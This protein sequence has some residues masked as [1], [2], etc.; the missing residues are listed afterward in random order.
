MWREPR[1]HLTNCRVVF[2]G[3]SKRGWSISNAGRTL[4]CAAASPRSPTHR[5][6]TTAAET[7]IKRRKSLQ[8]LTGYSDPA[9]EG[10]LYTISL[11]RCAVRCGVR[12]ASM[13]DM[14]K[15]CFPPPPL[16][17]TPFPPLFLPVCVNDGVTQNYDYNSDNLT[18]F[19]PIE[20]PCAVNPRPLLSLPS[21][22]ET[23]LHFAPQAR[24]R[25]RGGRAASS[26]KS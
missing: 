6:G 3:R 12:A 24:E 7:F 10:F 1:A 15:T 5:L 22:C 26:A 8:F 25:E 2:H 19:T 16:H 18:G 17:L 14:F 11:T 4:F 20:P 23:R 9:R 13:W 21:S